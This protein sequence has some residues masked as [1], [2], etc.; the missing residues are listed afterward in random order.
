MTTTMR[1]SAVPVDPARL[2]DAVRR[3]LADEADPRHA[4]MLRTYL[5]H[6]EAEF[7]GDVDEAMHTLVALPRFRFW[8]GFRNPDAPLVLAR[9]TIRENYT[10]AF[11]GG[12][13]PVHIDVERFI[14]SED[15][16]VLQGEQHAIVPGAQ[17]AALALDVSSEADH[18][19]VTR[20][21]LLVEFRDG[22]M[23]GEDHY[24]PL[25]HTIVEIEADG[26]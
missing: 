20:F 23:V 19:C 18:Y 25:P 3:R 15:G 14:V 11:A 4:A 8:C 16:L 26:A 17:L 22:L 7:R 12:F 21:A 24:W 1:R 6:L 13:P 10:R 9:A 2:L 5:H